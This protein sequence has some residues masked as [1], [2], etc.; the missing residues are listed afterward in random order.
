MAKE[1]NQEGGVVYP[2]KAVRPLFIR[3]IQSRQPV[4]VVKTD[5]EDRME[6]V[7][8]QALDVL[9]QKDNVAQNGPGAP[10][11][12]CIYRWDA[13][14]TLRETRSEEEAQ[15]PQLRSVLEWFAKA[16]PEGW[17]PSSPRD[18]VDINQFAPRRSVLFVY[19]ADYYL[20]P[21][22]SGSH[23]NP[24][25]TRTILAST[26]SLW[27]QEKHIFLIG[28]TNSA[29]IPPE[30]SAA[31]PSMGYPL[32]DKQ[33]LFSTVV[34]C[35][36]ACDKDLE[37]PVEEVELVAQRLL[38][39][40]N[41]T[42]KRLLVMSAVE[43]RVKRQREP[44]TPTGFD[45]EYLDEQKRLLVGSHQAINVI[46]PKKKISGVNGMD[47]VGGAQALKRWLISRKSLMSPEAGADGVDLPRGAFVYGVGGVGKDYIIECAAVEMG[48]PL[49][50]VDMAANK[51]P[52]MGQSHA[53]LRAMIAFAEANAPCLFHMQE[54]EKMMSGAMSTSSALSDG[55]VGNEMFG[56][57]LN[58]MQ[59]RTAPVLV[60][61]TANSLENITQP[62]LR[63]G[64]FDRIFFQD[65]AD[66][67]DR[68]EVLEKIIVGR[69]HSL[70]NIDIDKSVTLLD[71]FTNA[72]IKA[73]VNEAISGKFLEEGS[74]ADGFCL[75]QRHLDRAMRLV[76]STGKTRPKEI[77]AMRAF[78]KENGHNYANERMDAR[79]KDIFIDDVKKIAM[80][81][82][83]RKNKR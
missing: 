67:I 36:K 34:D 9:L 5:D 16:P 44:E 82:T 40:N 64:R 2:K 62:A 42:A 60:V 47:Q 21:N 48:L 38:G 69:G 59:S 8:M 35:Q 43:N 29:K 54:F 6:R 63:A 12:P 30:L 20:Q 32:P 76:H 49:L 17:A 75:E 72:E 14:F 51:G 26:K 28:N 77:A 46:I 78:A 37:L 25:L 27:R 53:N 61:A 68:K 70:E 19:D 50:T 57:W 31:V 18:L 52:L 45:L 13:T 66:P 24:V 3:W 11:S 10:G 4:V 7:E 65:L 74:K 79:D 56:T 58:W 41:C 23:S 83:D 1:K 39:L 80:G 33:F 81:E 15:V 71:G 73:V 55:G 22:Q